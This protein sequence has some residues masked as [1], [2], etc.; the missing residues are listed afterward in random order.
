MKNINRLIFHYVLEI[1]LV[2][3][4]VGISVPLW[5][6]LNKSDAAS[7]AKS[8]SKM[9]YLYMDINRYIAKNIFKDEITIINDTNITRNYELVLK[10]KK[11]VK[12]DDEK[13]MINQK[14]SKLKSLKYKE[15]NKYSYYLINKNDLVAS[16]EKYDIQ[17]INS[18]LNY[19]YIEYE[20]IESK[21]V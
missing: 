5:N 8:Y 11:N 3:I 20:I 7:I 15:D 16:S 19:K 12:I 14:N 9:D 4:F 10:M 13:I 1:C 18:K 6:K 21:N 2:L 17:F